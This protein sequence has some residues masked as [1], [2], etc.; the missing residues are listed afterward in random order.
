MI[1][2]NKQ[3]LSLA[4]SLFLISPVF[5]DDN[6]KLIGYPPD[7]AMGFL[8]LDTNNPAPNIKDGRAVD[9]LNVKLSNAFNLKKRPGKSVINTTLDDFDLS[10][11]AITGLFDAE[12]STGESWTLAFVGSKLKYDNSGTWTTVSGTATITSGQD[13]QWL[14]QMALDNAI[15]TNNVDKPLQV[16]KTPTKSEVSF[17]GLSNPITKA[18]AVIWFRNYLIFGNTT[19]NSIVRPTRF[20]W[21][22]VGTISTWSDADFVDLSSFSGDEIIGFQE[23]YGDL[24]IFMK[25]SIWR[26]SLV[27]GNDVFTFNKVVDSFGAISK[28]SIKLVNL[29]GNKVGVIYLN[30]N[31]FVYLFNGALITDIGAS[32]QPTL[33]GLNIARLQYAVGGYDDTD[34]YLSVSNGGQSKN[35]IVLVYNVDIGE[36]SKYDDLDFNAFARVK[37][38]TSTLK[39]YIGNYY[40]FVYW[41]DNPSNDNDVAG[42]TGI[43]DSVGFVNTSTETGAQILIDTGLTS[44][45]YT[46]ATVKITSGTGSGQEAVVLTSTTTGLVVVAA[47]STNPDTTSNYS[48]GA[49]N[50]Y[51]QTKWYDFGSAPRYKLFRGLY[52]WAKEDSDD[53]VDIMYLEDFGN[54][55]G[56]STI[57]LSPSSNSLWDVA[58]W[59][60][61]T[62]GTTGDKFYTT[63]LTGRGKTLSIKFSQDDINKN[64]EIYG[65]HLL[66]DR[67]DV[68]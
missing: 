58:L 32:I 2:W 50:A 41:M 48:V 39:S 57:S 68:E 35:D 1:G 3:L 60:V 10:S 22:N 25:K 53:S 65:F 34:Y 23:M 19:E 33:D 17:T 20:R 55:V 54:E 26:A 30:D 12:Y 15:C 38:S 28:E 37:E 51:Y 21:S 64:F 46:G 9:L 67:L 6:P 62:W 18:N 5:G 47:L 59:D 7:K 29:S 49:I 31:K 16:N 4:L 13:N 63:K 40:A 61:G 44:G 52:F 8:G 27:G 24:F 11:P 56:S 14:C 66:G 42:A 36:W 43:F 45:I